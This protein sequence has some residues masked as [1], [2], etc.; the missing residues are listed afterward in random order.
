MRT[1]GIQKVALG[2]AGI[3]ALAVGGAILLAPHAFYAS[4]GV[5]IGTDPTLLSELRGPAANLAALGAVML[6][7]LAVGALTHV[8]GLLAVIVYTA[9]PLGRLASI[10]VDGIPSEGIVIALLIE[11]AI[12]SLCAAAFRPSFVRPFVDVAERLPG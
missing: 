11:V 6:S 7:G 5:V 4:Y 8:A 3:T 12:A 1:T 2:I 9:I 10:L